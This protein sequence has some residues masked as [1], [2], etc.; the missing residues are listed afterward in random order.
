M[1]TASLQQPLVGLAD[2]G[3][4]A[5]CHP[6]KSQVLRSSGSV[7]QLGPLGKYAWSLRHKTMTVSS[8][9]GVSESFKPRLQS[10][11][12]RLRS[13]APADYGSELEAAPHLV[14]A[15]RRVAPCDTGMLAVAVLPV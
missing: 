10:F 9:V 12:P 2:L 3:L 11:N 4:Q 14:G 8:L 1:S 15:M 6:P 13:Q 7:C 5:W